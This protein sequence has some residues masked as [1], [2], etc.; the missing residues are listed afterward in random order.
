MYGGGITLRRYNLDY[1][2]T[3]RAL[4]VL[5]LPLVSQKKF[6][7]LALTILAA[8]R[9]WDAGH[10]EMTDY[11]AALNTQFV[12]HRHSFSLPSDWTVDLG[13]TYYSGVLYELYRIQ[14]QWWIDASVSKRMGN[15]RATLSARDPFNTNT[16]LTR[17]LN[18]AE[19]IAKP[20]RY[21]LARYPEVSPHIVRRCF[22]LH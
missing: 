17:H 16:P 18:R 19:G 4:L 8:Q 7:W 11:S 22:C 10:I 6:S 9:Q 20:A 12:Q 2:R 3:L 13:V 21:P 5:P 14:R 15:L 1:S